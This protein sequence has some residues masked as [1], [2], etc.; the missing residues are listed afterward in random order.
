MLTQLTPVEDDS[1]QKHIINKTQ[2]HLN[3]Y[4]RE[5]LRVLVVAKRILTQHQYEEWKRKLEE[6]ELSVD[7]SE[8]KVRDAFNL[9]EANMTLLGA[10]GNILHEIFSSH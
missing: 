8:K 6:A 10:T 5:G 9:I 2:Q 1:E 3:S 4:A 7:N